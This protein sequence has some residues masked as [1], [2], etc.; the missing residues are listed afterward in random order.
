MSISQKSLSCQLKTAR[1]AILS[2]VVCLLN[3]HRFAVGTGETSYAVLTHGHFSTVMLYEKKNRDYNAYRVVGE[4][5]YRVKIL[6]RNQ[7]AHDIHSKSDHT[8]DLDLS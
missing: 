6:H 3:V 5:T 8:E 7:D 1:F 2:A 4:V